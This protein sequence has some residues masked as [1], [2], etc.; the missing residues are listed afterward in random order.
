MDVFLYLG[1]RQFGLMGHSL[2]AGIGS[3]I[4]GSFKDEVKFFISIDG[5]GPFTRPEEF[6]SEQLRD[7]V[8]SMRAL[9]MKK[10]PIYKNVEHAVSVRQAGTSAGTLSMEGA[11]AL[12]GRVNV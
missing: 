10:L 11:K 12:V 7:H 8:L 3:M 4:A 9:S 6:V 5:L 1:I 2:G